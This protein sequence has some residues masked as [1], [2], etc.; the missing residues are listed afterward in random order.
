MIHCCNNNPCALLCTYYLHILQGVW[1]YFLFRL[2]TKGAQKAGQREARYER[3]LVI[4]AVYI[5]MNDDGQLG[6]DSECVQRQT[7]YVLM[8]KVNHQVMCV[9]DYICMYT[10]FTVV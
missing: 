9:C 1:G 6:S 7:K 8:L 5:R 3:G 10:T 2:S 4:Y